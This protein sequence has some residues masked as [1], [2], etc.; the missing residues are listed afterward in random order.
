MDVVRDI[1]SEAGSCNCE[2]SDLDDGMRKGGE[3]ADEDDVDCV[4]GCDG[5]GGGEK[6]EISSDIEV[7]EDEVSKRVNPAVSTI[8]RCN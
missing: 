5:G 3:N 8:S 6:K 2:E 7:D 1:G 4:S